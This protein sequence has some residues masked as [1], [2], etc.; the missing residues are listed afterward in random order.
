MKKKPT[1]FR[2]EE[3]VLTRATHV[4]EQFQEQDTQLKKD[5]ER[6]LKDYKKLF[7]HTKLLVKMS[8]QQQSQLTTLTEG[9]QSSNI[10]LQNKAEEA[11]EAV[12]ASEKKLAQFLEAIPVGVFVVD[13]SG[14]PYY[15]NQKAQQ[16]LGKGIIPSFTAEELTEIYQAYLAGTT[17]LYP[18]ERQPIVQALKGKISSVDDI[19]IHQNDKIIPIEVW[20]TPIFEENGNIAYAIAVFQDITERKHADEERI[21]FTKKLAKLN[22][23][24]ERFVP[25][26]FL[27]LLDKQSVIDVQLGDQI[28][29]E[30]TLLFADIR[31]FTSLSEEMTPQENFN[32]LNAYLSRMT[33]IIHKYHGFIDKYIGDA[34]MAL[35]PTSADD[36]LQAAIGML[37]TLADYNKTRGRPG[38]PC[39]GIGIGIHTGCLMLGTVGGQNRMD[40]T[41]I[42]DAVNLASRIEGMT[43]IYGMALLIS[44]ETYTRLLDASQ[45]AI[46]PL[47]RVKVKGKSKAVTVYEVFDSD[48]PK[49]KE[50]KNKTLADFEIGLALYRQKKFAEA[51]H[52][53]KQMLRVYA[54]DK[55]AL[56]YIERCEHFQK[57]GVPDDWDGVEALD[58]KC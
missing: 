11:E 10:E 49:I 30:M 6:L 43:K 2:N 47:E 21:Q 34:I 26:Q 29:K 53:F 50:L 51:Q 25:S 57:D 58:S 17:Q 18:Q 55:A 15:A 42:S 40:G 13:A 19:D 36:A 5:Y 7:K 20:G 54:D 35:F 3:E 27:S 32:F 24:Y 8:D 44:E 23:A 39:F 45:Y 37:K 46:R 28:E 1:L 48:A 41:V 22:Q 33:P 38:R 14:K 12:R 56:I 16:I 9:L 4:L 31:E 52:Y